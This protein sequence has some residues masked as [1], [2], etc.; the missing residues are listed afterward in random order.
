MPH[1]AP[2]FL[3]AGYLWLIHLIESEGHGEQDGLSQR[4]NLNEVDKELK[5][6]ERHNQ[7][8]KC[9]QRKDKRKKK[10]RIKVRW[11]WSINRTA[12]HAGRCLSVPLSPPLYRPT[13]AVTSLLA[14]SAV[15]RWST[16]PINLSSSPSVS[17]APPFISFPCRAAPSGKRLA[18]NSPFHQK[19]RAATQLDGEH[20]S[21]RCGKLC[22]VLQTWWYFWKERATNN[23]Q[24][25]K[26]HIIYCVW[27]ES[28]IRS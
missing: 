14:S 24:N 1:L 12:G 7:H 9:L 18:Q 11:A 20:K 26:Q 15:D 10:E 25:Q 13:W 5:K 6:V 27:Y 28:E 8:K 16:K 3:S 23:S 22:R 17:P 19:K 21:E 4:V 2:L